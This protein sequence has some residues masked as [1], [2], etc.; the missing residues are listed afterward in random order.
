[1]KKIGIFCAALLALGFTACDDTSDLGKMQVNEQEPVMEAN[2][3]GISYLDDFAKPGFDLNGKEGK[4][5]NLLS[6]SVVQDGYQLPADFKP[7]FRL[8]VASN[9]KFSDEILLDLIETETNDIR[10]NADDFNDAVVTLYGRE[11]VARNVWIAVQGYLVNGTQLTLLSNQLGMKEIAVTPMLDAA[12]SH[13]EPVYY[14]KTNLGGVV[15][16]SHSDKHQYDDPFFSYVLDVTEDD[17]TSLGGNVQWQVIPESVQNAGAT[18]GLLGVAADTAAD[19][20]SGDLIA[21]GKPGELTAAAKYLIVF[22]ALN[23]TYSISYAADELYVWVQKGQFNK[24]CLLTTDDNVHFSGV[25]ILLS[26][27]K[28]TA[29]K[30]FKGLQFGTSTTAPAGTLVA[31]NK[32]LTI[33]VET[34]GLTWMDVDL[35]ALKYTVQE[36]K[37][38]GLVGNMTGWGDEATGT[39]DIELTPNADFNV[40]TATVTFPENGDFKIRSNGNWDGFNLGGELDNLNYGGANLTCEPGTYDVTLTI[41]YD[42]VYSLKMVK[43]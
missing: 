12:Y 43:K 31:G 18:T 33:A 17:L 21:N 27:W 15:K 29:Q 22:D 25:A 41:G 26:G 16:M 23:N 7:Y 3:I 2:G 35:A 30:N 20:L 10:V 36:V 13:I 11:P 4:E 24:A 9:D 39:P 5:L 37:T 28:L 32:S 34:P 40:W 14:L 8:R 6:W 38:L 42:H 1:M 19:T